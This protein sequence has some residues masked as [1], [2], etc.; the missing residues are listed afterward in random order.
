[1][2]KYRLKKDAMI[3]GVFYPLG[4]VVDLPNNQHGKPDHNM[5]RVTDGAAESRP[6]TV[7]KNLPA[8]VETSAA[9]EGGV[10]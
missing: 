4:S 2:A 10:P 7:R 9:D 8:E 1:M 5:E 6:A 3:G